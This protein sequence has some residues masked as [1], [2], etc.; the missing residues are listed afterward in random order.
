MYVLVGLYTKDLLLHGSFTR[1]LRN[2]V[3]FI[4]KNINRFEPAYQDMMLYRLA[5]SYS[6]VHQPAFI[7]ERRAVEN[8]DNQQIHDKLFQR[9]IK[10]KDWCRLKIREHVSFNDI[11]AFNLPQPLINYC[12][13][14]LYDSR[15]GLQCVQ[16]VRKASI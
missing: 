10:L 3:L 6:L 7:N 15:Y 4:L 11:P 5:S 13:F 2:F 12:S 8:H 16:E 9:P 1:G 14:G